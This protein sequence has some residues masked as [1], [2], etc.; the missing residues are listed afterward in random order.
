MNPQVRKRE[1]YSKDTYSSSTGVGSMCNDGPVA[2]G[3]T[4]ASCT[5]G[6]VKFWRLREKQKKTKKGQD[7]NEYLIKFYHHIISFCKISGI[8]KCKNCVS[9]LF[10]Y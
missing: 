10:V 1:K 6:A 9:T 2:D 4:L 3:S 8:V 7:S 5:I